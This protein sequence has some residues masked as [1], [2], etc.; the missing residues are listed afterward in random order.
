MA[1]RSE[2]LTAIFLSLVLLISICNEFVAGIISNNLQK[3]IEQDLALSKTYGETSARWLEVNEMLQRN[4]AFALQGLSNK[5]V[6][7]SG[8]FHKEDFTEQNWN[9]WKGKKIIEFWEYRYKAAWRNLRTAIDET[10]KIKNNQENFVKKNKGWERLES[11]LRVV[12][13]CLIILSLFLY[14][15]IIRTSKLIETHNKANSA[16]A[17]SR[18]AD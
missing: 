5:T 13:I 12:Q 11:V 14:G 1:D 7:E 18:A 8:R 6:E 10:N 4:L 16:D 2:T 9:Y 3:Q 15:R 17:K